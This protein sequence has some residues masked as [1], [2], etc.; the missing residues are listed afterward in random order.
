MKQK[1]VLKAY[2]VLISMGTKATGKTA[3]SLFRL[4]N[5]LKELVDFQAEEEVK[6]A[7]KH[8]GEILDNGT[9]KFDDDEQKRQFLDEKAALGE[10]DIDPEIEPARVQIDAVP[11][12]TL[13]DIE[14]LDGFVIF[15]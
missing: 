3:L 4:K 10:M 12:I 6:L 7:K 9:I 15:E 5:R 13:S 11:E 2:I 8:G 14:S 1:Q